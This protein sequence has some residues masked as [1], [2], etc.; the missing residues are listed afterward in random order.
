MKVEKMRVK[1]RNFCNRKE[2]RRTMAKG[3]QDD[4]AHIEKLSGPENFQV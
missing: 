2:V 3:P 1:K 4:V